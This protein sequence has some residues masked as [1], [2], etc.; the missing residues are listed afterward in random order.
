MLLTI[1]HTVLYQPLF[2]ILIFFYN[3][4]PIKDVGWAIILLTILIRIILFPL[5]KS[6]ITSQ[7]RL[8]T[9]KPKIDKLKEKHKGDKEAF[10]KASMELYKRE[11][12]NPMSS[13]LPLLI[14]LPILIAVYQVF[15]IGLGNGSFDLLYSFVAH[16]GTINSMFLGIVNLAEP[17]TPLAVLAGISQYIQTKMIIS[18][19]GKNK[20]KEKKGKDDIASAMSKQMLY[21][22]PILTI[23][24]GMSLPSGLVLYWFISI[25]LTVVQ[26]HLIFSKQARK[27]TG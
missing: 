15:R 9:L 5:S 1:Y 13:C 7:K 27:E 2:N 4:V 14:Q 8:Q 10:G 23:F 12:I 24:I 20:K 11:K 26:Q 16:P 6:S 17:N 19:K 22:M 25:V 18:T 3:L 21:M